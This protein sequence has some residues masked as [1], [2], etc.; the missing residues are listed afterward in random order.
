M[1]RARPFLY[2]DAAVSLCTTCFRRI[3]AKI[4]FEDGNVYM[5]KRCS[6]HGFERVHIAHPD[7]Q[8]LIPFDTYNLF[9]RDHLEQSRLAPLRAAQASIPADFI[10]PPPDPQP[11]LRPVHASK[12]KGRPKGRPCMSLHTL[13]AEST[14]SATILRR[15]AILSPTES[16]MTA[17]VWQ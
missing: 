13:T 12:G 1:A 7:A 8:R 5:L 11:R 14:A 4:V 6:Q 17:P 16:A 15:K 9:Y 10:A 3:D 2:Y